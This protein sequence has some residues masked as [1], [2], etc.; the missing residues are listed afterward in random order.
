MR[1]ALR[2]HTGEEWEREEAP[3]LLSA[4]GKLEVAAGSA[5]G[6]GRGPSG[7]TERGGLLRL[8]LL[9]AAPHRRRAVLW[10]HVAAAA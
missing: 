5:P 2:H 7:V 1:R 9:G 3:D 8:P 10:L 4:E 6:G